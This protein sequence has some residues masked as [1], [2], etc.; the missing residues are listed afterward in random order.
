MNQELNAKL[1]NFIDENAE[2]IAKVLYV[3]PSFDE[4]LAYLIVKPEFP[5]EKIE[6]LSDF[7]EEDI[8]IDV[9][10]DHAESIENVGTFAREKSFAL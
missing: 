2:F 6:Q 4:G 1:K 8:Y 10:S 5:E 7:Y 9:S 3:N